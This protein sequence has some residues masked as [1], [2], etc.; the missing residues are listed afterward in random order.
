MAGGEFEPSLIGERD[1]FA[2]FPFVDR[3][4]L[5]DVNVAPGLQTKLGRLK[6][7]LRRSG[8]VDH[9][10]LG[11]FEQFR[12]LHEGLLDR[13]AIAQLLRHQRLTVA[14]SDDLG[15]LDPLDLSGVGISNL[16]ASDDADLKH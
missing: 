13:K 2:G 3:E 10:G 12:Q 8:D 4:W 7:N 11:T 1:Q 15:T 5:L 6:V 9:V 16:A 14:D